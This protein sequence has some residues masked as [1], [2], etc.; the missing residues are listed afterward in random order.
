MT[1]EPP[2]RTLLTFVYHWSVYKHGCDSPSICGNSARL[3][4]VDTSYSY[5]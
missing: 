1:K 3:P 2:Q 5:I 4:T